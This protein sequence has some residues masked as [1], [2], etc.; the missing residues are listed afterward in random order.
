M[1]NTKTLSSI[2]KTGN[3]TAFDLNFNL[4]KNMPYKAISDLGEFGLIDRISSLVGPTL[5]ASP[6]LLTGI[7]DDCAVYQPTAGMLEVTTTDLLV[8]KVHFDL[9][10]TPLKHLGSKSISVNVS[11]ICAMN[12]TPQYALIGIAVPPSF[13]VEMIEELYKGMSHAARIY[14]VA[15]AGG[16][17][18]V[19]RSGLFISVTMTGEVSGERLTRR[20]GAKPGEM[21][22]VT[23]TLGGAAAGL[24]LLM[25][26]KNIMLEHIEHHE[27]YNKS[28]MVDLEE[29]ADAIKE[30]LLPAARIDII[31]FFHSRNIN[32]TAM[33][34]ISDGLSSDLRHLCN[35]SGTGAVIHEGRIPVHSGA[36]RIA[37]ELRDDALGWSLTGGEDYQLLFTLPKERFPDIAE[38]DDISI[39]GEITEKDAGISLVDIYGMSIDLEKLPGYDHF[40]S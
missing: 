27:P 13:S 15:I 38:H 29:Y 3:K 1:L 16:D 33:I 18:S 21:I 26:E 20:S 5:D 14:G 6:N 30:Q 31:R 19:S 23:G 2:P 40:R 4:T 25:R 35:S 22:C 34:D 9:L 36:R 8:E 28:L 32:P 17:T 11:D 7:G 24:R 37:D 12:A 39:I 10:T